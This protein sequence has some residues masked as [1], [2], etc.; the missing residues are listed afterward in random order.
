MD[1]LCKLERA[2]MASSHFEFNIFTQEIR[3][4]IIIVVYV[5]FIITMI[6]Y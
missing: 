6:D 5:I 3:N 1:S 4:F 2:S